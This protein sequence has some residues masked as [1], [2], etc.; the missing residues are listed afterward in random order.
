MSD[1]FR[2]LVSETPSRVW[3]NNPTEEEIGLALAAG[4][5]G[6][7]L[8][9]FGPVQH[10]RDSF[11]AGWSGVVAIAER[12]VVARSRA[13]LDGVASVDQEVLARREVRGT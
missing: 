8:D 5:V 1:Y 11:L 10:F 3:V 6:S 4:A 13:A 9:G 12:R 7:E 2:R